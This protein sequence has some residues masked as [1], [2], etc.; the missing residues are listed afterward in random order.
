MEAILI[1]V[2]LLFLTGI[3]IAVK[4]KSSTE[5]TTKA[6]NEVLDQIVQPRTGEKE[7]KEINGDSTETAM[8][9]GISQRQK[10]SRVDHSINHKITRKD[11]RAHELR[12]QQF[13]EQENYS[14]LESDLKKAA[15]REARV[16]R[17]IRKKEAQ[18]ERQLREK[19][20][21]NTDLER[22]A[23]LKLRSRNATRTFLSA[24][25]WNQVEHLAVDL[26]RYHGWYVNL[27]QPGVDRSIDAI[28]T[29]P[30]EKRKAVI[31]VKDWKN[32]V[33]GPVVRETI[34]AAAMS[35][36]SEV[37]VITTGRFTAD[38]RNTAKEYSGQSLE[39]S[40]ELWDGD[41]LVDLIIKM[42]NDDFV[43][44]VSEGDKLKRIYKNAL[45]EGYAAD[46]HIF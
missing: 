3:F 34:G 2:V 28:A 13:L 31:Q 6:K 41:H 5:P 8:G 27:T 14:R 25:S 30:N 24:L 26:L 35:G 17:A 15:T 9:R 16:E 45:N 1:W 32:P 33:S 36:I 12:V 4:E 42:S 20:K 7:S 46:H 43:D 40:C 21:R 39:K 10:S 44:M 23:K 29:K 18:V 19:E 11:Q 22:K 38:A 37:F